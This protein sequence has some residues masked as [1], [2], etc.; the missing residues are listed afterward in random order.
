MKNSRCE[1][2]PLTAKDGG[3]AFGLMIIVYL[4]TSFI[5]QAIALALF[6]NGSLGY[7]VVSSLLAP[8]S[9]VAVK[10]YFTV[11]K[12]C[13]YLKMCK[14]EKF[15]PIFS[16]SAVLLSAGMFLGLGF[17]NGA[18]AELLRKANL[19]VSGIVLPLENVGH[20]ILF[21]ILFALIPAVVEE[22]F[23]RGLLLTT[24]GA[25]KTIFVVVYIS[26]SFALYHCSLTQFIYQLIY[27]AGLTLLALSAKSVLPCVLAHFINNFAVILLEYLKVNVDLFNPIF[28]A[29]GLILLVAFALMILF[30]LKKKEKVAQQEQKS[31]LK[32][33]LPFGAFGTVIC[34]LLI[35]TNLF[36]V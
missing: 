23:F 8:L 28:I 30:A 5:G 14:V 3:F 20:L 12:K 24:L 36:A 34:L 31:A 7:I 35:I 33:Y 17:V 29:I 2:L 1:N 26:V 15:N 19:N 11:A 4:F 6:E 13:N 21:S 27:G 32:F 16:L 9:I 22:L 25:I 10:V 18:F